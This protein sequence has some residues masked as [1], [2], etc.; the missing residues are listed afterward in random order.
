[1]FPPRVE[2]V[3]NIDKVDR[4][5]RA[6]APKELAILLGHLPGHRFVRRY[7]DDMGTYRRID[8]L[9][10][11]K[12]LRRAK[13]RPVE[14]ERQAEPA[15]QHGLVAREDDQAASFLQNRRHKCADRVVCLGQRRAAHVRLALPESRMNSQ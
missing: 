5:F 8:G 2:I 7:N 6:E 12:G 4:P 9:S 3:V 13:H 1:M 14:H 11:K 15:R 10:G